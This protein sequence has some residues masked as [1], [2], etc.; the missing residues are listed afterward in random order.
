MKIVFLSRLLAIIT[1]A[2]FLVS[3]SDGDHN[4]SSPPNPPPNP[5]EE[6]LGEGALTLEG[7]TDTNLNPVDA[8][9]MFVLKTSTFATDPKEIKLTINDKPVDPA[10]LQMT[11]AQILVPAK[12]DDGRNDIVFK[13][14][15]SVGRP[16]YMQ[17]TIW[18]GSN[19]L[20]VAIVDDNGA[21]VTGNVDVKLKLSDAPDIVE[22]LK[23]SGW[24]G[25]FLK[26]SWAYGDRRSTIRGKRFGNRGRCRRR[27]ARS[28]APDRGRQRGYRG[29]GAGR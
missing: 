28:H 29:A 22:T 12:L 18:A 3:C 8:T 1:F 10:A 19:Q 20:V 13:A 7:V 24:P 25:D 17:K 15:D 4:A 23:I 5:L 9:L 27:P 26:C 2:L 14:Y 11:S 21:P 6:V 16:V